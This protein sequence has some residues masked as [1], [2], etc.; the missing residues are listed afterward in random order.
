M[1]ALCHTRRRT[2]IAISGRN[3]FTDSVPRAF[4]ARATSLAMSIDDARHER[5]AAIAAHPPVI[6]HCF[7]ARLHAAPASTRAMP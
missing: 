4:L 1:A 7:H 6:A 3:D 5:S 2:S